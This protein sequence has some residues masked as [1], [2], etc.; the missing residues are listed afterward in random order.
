MWFQGEDPTA[1]YWMLRSS[2]NKLSRCWRILCFIL[3]NRN[4][5]CRRHD[6][7]YQN[8][9]TKQ[10]RGIFPHSLTENTPLRSHFSFG[11]N[12]PLVC[13]FV[14]EM[15]RSWCLSL[16]EQML[17]LFFLGFLIQSVCCCSTLHKTENKLDRNYDD[18]VTDVDAIACRCHRNYT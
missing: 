13:T 10:H 18:S 7:A 16:L 9:V 15:G 5:P 17:L 11:R 14:Q 2:G 1:M 8:Q 6:D 4:G 12:I 3:L